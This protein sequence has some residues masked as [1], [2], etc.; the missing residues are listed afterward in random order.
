MPRDGWGSLPAFWKLGFLGKTCLSAD[1]A[2]D[3]S[4]GKKMLVRPSGLSRRG[5]SRR[6]ARRRRC[7]LSGVG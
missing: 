6:S 4:E 7:L 3:I 5:L 1:L 2:L